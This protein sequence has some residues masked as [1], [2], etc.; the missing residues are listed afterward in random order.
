MASESEDDLRRH[1]RQANK[2]GL[3]QTP[4]VFAFCF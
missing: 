2:S 1:L 3:A 4:T